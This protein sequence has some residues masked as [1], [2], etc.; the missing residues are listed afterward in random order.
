MKVKETHIPGVLIIE[1]EVFGDARGFFKEIWRADRYRSIGINENFVQDN[2]SY[3]TRGVLRGLHYQK[4]HAQ[5]KL[6][7][8][9]T[10]RVFDVAV[11]IRRGSPA[12]GRW[13]GVELSGDNH[14]QFWL[15]P[16]LAHGF[17]VISDEAYF[18][19]KCTDVYAPEAEGG[20]AWDDPA[21]G[22]EW[23][24]NDVILSGKDQKYPA[25]KDIPPERL[26]VFQ[27]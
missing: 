24:L 17:C 19:Y 3:S 21:I 1:P 10:G 4:P 25:L 18:T 27:G 5:G 7:S 20:V 11:D 22:I 16:G 23:P 2:L 6:V 13:A 8:V 14:H 15:P 26:P 9:I 12:F